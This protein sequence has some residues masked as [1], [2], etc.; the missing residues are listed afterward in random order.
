MPK[1][2]NPFGDSSPL[3]FKAHIGTKEIDM[4]VAQEEKMQAV[5]GEDMISGGSRISR[6]GGVDPQRGHFSAKM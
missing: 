2:T 3:Q 4:G 5:Y 6:R 1:R